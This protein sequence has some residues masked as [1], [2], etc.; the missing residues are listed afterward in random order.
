[1]QTKTGKN[2]QISVKA[3]KRSFSLPNI[4]IQILQ[5]KRQCQK[6][7]LPMA[8][9]MILSQKFDLQKCFKSQKFVF[10]F[11]FPSFVKRSMN[12]AFV[13]KRLNSSENLCPIKLKTS[14]A[15]NRQRSHDFVA[16][17]ESRRDCCHGL[18]EKSHHFS[19][20]SWKIS[21]LFLKPRLKTSDEWENLARFVIVYRGQ[22]IIKDELY[23][24]I[25]SHTRKSNSI[26]LN[27]RYFKVHL[28]FGF[29]HIWTANTCQS[30]TQQEIRE[31]KW[32]HK[33]KLHNDTPLD[34]YGDSSH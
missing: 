21:C 11:C 2:V 10:H 8:S 1:M 15:P 27:C 12:P 17:F 13:N 19:N 29:V 34:S 3:N 30:S 16:A 23:D 22:M 20:V 28:E 14:T 9:W 4:K 5:I 25:D 33:N 26:P 6:F 7:F 18:V 32:K 31:R 24:A